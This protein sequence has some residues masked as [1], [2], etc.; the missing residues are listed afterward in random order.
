MLTRAILCLACFACL[1]PAQEGESGFDARFTGA[2]LRLDYHHAGT[3]TEEHV[4]LDVVRLEGPWPGSR[5]Q[6]VDATDMGKYRFLVVEPGS[7]SVLYSRGFASIYGEWET[8][9]EARERWRAFHESQRFPEPRV[10]VEVVL[11]KRGADGAF[12]EL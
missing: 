8:T 11:E 3:A 1:A 5:T 6:L 12:V 7:G 10:P 2:T 4:A 9:A